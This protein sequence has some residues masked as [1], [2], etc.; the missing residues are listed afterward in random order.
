MIETLQVLLNQYPVGELTLLP[1]DKTLF[2][3]YEAYLEDSNRPI[4]SQ[5][6]FT[7]QNTLIKST[8]AYQTKAP[9]FFSN[10]LPEGALKDLIVK[11]THISP[12]RDFELLK[13]LGEDLPGAIILKPIDQAQLPTQTH[14]DIDDIDHK[15]PNDSYFKFSLAGVQLKFSAIENQSGGLTIPGRGMGG[16][17]IIKLPSNQFKQVPENEYT[18]LKLAKSIGI[19][20]PEIRRSK[21]TEIANLPQNL[22][23]HTK[24]N[25]DALVIKRFDRSKNTERVHIEDFAQVYGLYPHKKYQG[26][27]TANILNMIGEV[28][29]Q[30]EQFEFIKRL[31]FNIL[32]GNGDMHLKNWSFIYPNS[33]TVKLAPAY[34]YLATHVFIQ[35]DQLALS[36]SGEKRIPQLTMKHFE[37]LIE[38]TSLPKS[39]TLKH[40]KHTI[41]QTIESWSQIKNDTLLEPAI[42][43]AISKHIT[44][45]EKNLR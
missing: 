2:Y 4:L 24:L 25:Q 26:V 20:V 14:S 11:Q 12:T 27:S 22:L 18:M 44:S 21:L 5:S 38:V 29:G 10:L 6:F 9:P 36:L 33:H 17:W 37:K 1:G 15:L 23:S 16:N 42:I 39:M 43:E 31:V 28:A 13:Y 35:H 19:S 30:N 3:F 34:D 8:R 40:I 7:P 41:S 45:T 32:I